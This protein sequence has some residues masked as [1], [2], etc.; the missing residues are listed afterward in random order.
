M[1]E[2]HAHNVKEVGSIPTGSTKYLRIVH[3][4]DRIG[5]F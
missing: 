1:V 3:S 5:N 2:R 4:T